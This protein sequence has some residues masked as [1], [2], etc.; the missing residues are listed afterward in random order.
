MSYCA[1][2]GSNHDPDVPCFQASS[3][4]LRSAGIGSR[5]HSPGQ[6][7]RKTAGLADRWV[8]KGLVTLLAIITALIILIVLFEEKAL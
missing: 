3:Q 1:I 5:P 8:I 6:G 7:F 2:C 4:T